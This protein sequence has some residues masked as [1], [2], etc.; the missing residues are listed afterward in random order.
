MSVERAIYERLSTTSGVTALVGTRITPDT[1]A[2]GGNLPAIVY[3][4]NS[5]EAINA[6]LSKVASRAEIEVL[7]I[8]STKASAVAIGSAVVESLDRYFVTTAFVRILQSIHLRSV[9]QYLPPSAGE[10]VGMF[11]QTSVFG[12]I[13]E[14][15]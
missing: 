11:T 5:E 4:V 3:G 8:S 6:L 12:V 10:S 13:Y 2:Q 15:V 1:R 9:G 14:K 7:A